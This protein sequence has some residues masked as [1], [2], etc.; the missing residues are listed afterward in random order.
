MMPSAGRTTPGRSSRASLVVSTLCKLSPG[1]YT[2]VLRTTI[3]P[4]QS[5]LR[6][7]KRHST[8]PRGHCKASSCLNKALIT[9]K[10]NYRPAKLSSPRGYGGSRGCVNHVQKVARRRRWG[11]WEGMTPPPPILEVI[12]PACACDHCASPSPKRGTETERA[13]GL[14]AS[15][16]TWALYRRKATAGVLASQRGAEA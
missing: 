4:I 6:P 3:H 9:R 15:Q 2:P 14:I 12:E 1:G 13:L 7:W 11:G 5:G 10:C 8:S 16:A